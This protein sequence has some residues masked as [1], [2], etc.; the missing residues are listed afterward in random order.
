MGTTE[1]AASRREETDVVVVGARVSGAPAAIEL[2][3]MGRRVIAFDGATFPSDTLSTHVI[4]PSCVA[5]LKAL[6]ALDRILASGTP[7]IP[8]FVVNHGGYEPRLT[9]TAVDGIDYCM[10][11]R[12]PTLDLALVEVAK[13]AG[14]EV[15][16]A[17]KV[18]ELIWAGGRV[19]GVRWKDREGQVGETLCKL[20]VGADGRRSTIAELV[21]A[22]DPYRR[23]E[24]G[25]GLV[26]MYADDP[27]GP[28]DRKS[29]YQW[30]IGDTLGMFFPTDDDGALVLFMGPKEDVPKFGQDLAYW[31]HMLDQNRCLKERVAGGAPRTKLRKA[32]D[33]F[34]YFRRSSGPGW[35]LVGDAGHFKDPVIAQGIRDAIYHGRRL[36]QAAGETLDDAPWL[37]RRLYEWELQRD[38]ECMPSYYF[39]L[40]LTKT[41]PVSA[42]EV[43]MFRDL[44]A[45]DSQARGLADVF[46]REHAFNDYATERRLINWTWRALRRPDSDRRWTLRQVRD[47]LS[48]QAQLKRDQARLASGRRVNGS[49]WDPWTDGAVPRPVATTPAV[50]VPSA[51][52]EPGYVRP[53]EPE[54]S[55]VETSEAERRRSGRPD[56]G[57]SASPTEPAR[58]KEGSLT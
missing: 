44:A 18:T 25:R 50:T 49:T 45:D 27:M 14:V 28:A 7:Q 37:D 2:A 39:G 19:A 29:L 6:G 26:F 31:N 35:A 36:G 23:H 55:D 41:H 33:T 3:R 13:E 38:R 43:E 5:E 17:T 48:F 52:P 40:R 53:V 4:E 32:A 51:E 46:G 9:W 8:Y 1:T 16:E 47:E 15:R 21:G 57:Q 54:T 12:R 34:S 56:N 42:I 20:V 24:N 10:C 58:T 30:R 22:K 11:P